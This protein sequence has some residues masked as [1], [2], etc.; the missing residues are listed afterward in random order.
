MQHL[1]KRMLVAAAEL[2][3]LQ[4]FQHRIQLLVFLAPFQRI[5]AFGFQRFHL[6]NGMTEDKDILFTHLLGNLDVR[7]VQ[8]PD[9]ER[10]IQ[11]QLHIA[12]AGGFL[13]GSRNLLGD[14]R[15]RDQFF[16]P[17][18]RSSPAGTPPSVCRP[19]SRRC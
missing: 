8:R 4:R 7:A 17:P 2:P 19:L 6:F 13:T 16:P 15:R 9:S 18:T 12:G 3:A 10:A 1:I 14:I 11:R 5:V